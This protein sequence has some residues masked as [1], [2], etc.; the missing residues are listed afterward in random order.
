M[1]TP[2]AELAA[3]LDAWVAHFDDFHPTNP[4]ENAWFVGPFQ[5]WRAR[6]TVQRIGANDYI[7]MA[8]GA[9]IR[10]PEFTEAWASRFGPID[11]PK[12]ELSVLPYF[13]STTWRT[14]GAPK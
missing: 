13:M 14:F 2:D 9:V 4:V 8:I 12:A 6:Q 11:N 10:H 1:S 3:F 5:D 7:D